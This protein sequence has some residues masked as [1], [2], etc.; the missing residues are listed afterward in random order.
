MKHLLKNPQ[1]KSKC[2]VSYLDK[3]LKLPLNEIKIKNI[4]SN[5]NNCGI[6]C[7]LSEIINDQS[8]KIIEEMDDFSLETL[9]QHTEWFEDEINVNNLYSNSYIHDISSIN[10]LFNNRTECYLNGVSKELPDI[11]EVIQDNKRLKEFSI[12]VE[13]QFLGLFIYNH[14]IMN[15]WII[16]VINIEELIEDFVD[17]NKTE[18]ETDWEEEIVNYEKE[19]AKKIEYYNNTLETAKNLLSEIRN[20]TNFNIW[21]KKILK[22]KKY[23]LKL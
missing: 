8:I 18:I 13:I 22:L 4:I 5:S 7:Y 21:D 15:K 17:W 14:A 19:I 3:P 6:E 16:K 2:Y 11:I 23:I 12:N 20:E 10:L 9:I 1:K